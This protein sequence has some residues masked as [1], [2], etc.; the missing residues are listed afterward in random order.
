[1]YY[2]TYFL[3]LKRHVCLVASVTIGMDTPV[4]SLLQVESKH[5]TTL[6]RKL[7]YVDGANTSEGITSCDACYLS[8]LLNFFCSSFLSL[9]PQ[10]MVRDWL[11][12]PIYVHAFKY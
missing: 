11:H 5:S 10:M 12:Y 8:C 2:S 4:R 3:S 6:K 1:M 9:V 7:Q